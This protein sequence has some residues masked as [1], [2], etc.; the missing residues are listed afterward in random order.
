MSNQVKMTTKRDSAPTRIGRSASKRNVR[1]TKRGRYDQNVISVV[2]PGDDG[3]EVDV[4]R[5]QGI[6]NSRSGHGGSRE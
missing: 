1:K 3:D 4:S 6:M 2:E 5:D